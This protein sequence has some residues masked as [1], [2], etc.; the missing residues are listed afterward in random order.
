MHVVYLIDSLIAGGAERSLAA[1]APYYRSL[2]IELDVAY[3]YERDNVWLPTIEASGAPTFSL[4]GRGG[5]VG[6]LRRATELLRD[7]RPDVVH[8]TLFDAD[9]TGRLASLFARVPTVCSLV[10]ENYGASQL[11]DPR[12]AAWKV[13]AAQLIDAATSR[14]VARFHAVSASVAEVMSRRLHVPRER[15]DVIPRGRDPE[16]LGSRTDARRTAARAALEVPADVTLLLAVGRHEHQKGFDVLLRAFELVRRA[17]RDVRLVIAGR[18]G[19]VTQSLNTL[20]DR[21]HVSDAVSFLGFRD[22]V[23]ELLCAADVF[24]SASRWEGSPGGI[25]EAMALETPIVATD[26][27]ATTEVFGVADIATLVRVDDAEGLAHALL[28]WPDDE[29]HTAT[30]TQAGRA[31]FLARFTIE[32]VAHEM[33]DFYSRA[34]GGQTMAGPEGLP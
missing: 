11:S 13:R 15:V 20:A 4:A 25:I 5:H 7:R 12:L 8:T 18:D 19:S 26:I 32:R 17:R 6:S 28:S 33:A 34:L 2:G 24:V 1:L 31:R 21:L 22:D 16:T 9:V 29:A 3:L 27:K 30:R 14:R 23:P 10:N